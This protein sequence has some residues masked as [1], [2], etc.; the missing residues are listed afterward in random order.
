MR[1]KVSFLMI[2]GKSK[3][4]L[5]SEAK[6]RD[7]FELNRQIIGFIGRKSI[8]TVRLGGAGGRGGY[9]VIKD[10]HFKCCKFT[11]H[12]VKNIFILVSKF[13]KKSFRTAEKFS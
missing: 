9:K 8:T 1:E 5:L 6:F 10:Y 3:I 11:Q 13:D 2:S 12:Q 4:R 7:D